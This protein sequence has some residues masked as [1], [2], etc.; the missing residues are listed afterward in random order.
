MFMAIVIPVVVEA[1]HVA[2]LSGEVAARR[3]EA[4]RV[5]DRVLTESIVTTNWTSSTSGT[6]VEGTHQFRWTINTQPWPED[7]A[8]QIVGAEVKFTASGRD[9]SVRLNTLAMLPTMTATTMTQ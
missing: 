6:V 8:V 1:L 9:Y 2:S 7:S 5:A 4:T 3:A